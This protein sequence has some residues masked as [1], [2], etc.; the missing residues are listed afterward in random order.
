MKNQGLKQT[1]KMQGS[2]F[3]S[4]MGNNSSIPKVGEWATICMYSDREVAKVHA[5]SKD[6]KRVT[7]ELCD[8][9]HDKTKEGGMGH[10]N[11]VHKP[12]GNYYDIV[13]RNNAWRRVV[14]SYV[15]TDDFIKNCGERFPSRALT[16][17]Q[18]EE[19]YG[20]EHYPQK[21]MEGI[22]REKKSYPKLSI[23]FGACDYHYDWT[24]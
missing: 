13:Y 9:S 1:R 8:T 10:Q 5:V 3:N 6:S 2:F 14:V 20:G 24:F 18:R 15:F 16:D 11:W 19:I 7:L 21:V 4:L 22:T 17:E 23:L 12:T